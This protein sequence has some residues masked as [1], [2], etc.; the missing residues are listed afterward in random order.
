M[1][2]I[3]SKSSIYY[4][5]I[6]LQSILLELDKLFD[7]VLSSRTNLQQ[8]AEKINKYANLELAIDHN[9]NITGL[10]AYYCNNQQTKIGFI[11]LLGVLPEYQNAGIA[12]KLLLNCIS[13]CIREKMKIVT[14]KTEVA[15]SKAIS[16][17]QKNGFNMQ[18]MFYDS[19]IKKVRLNLNL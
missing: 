5:L 10:L 18:E 14:V 7:P 19:D 6:K 9:K 3:T 11:T 12:K 8:Y 13:G 16:F 1:I 2:T 15:N 4:D 17:Y